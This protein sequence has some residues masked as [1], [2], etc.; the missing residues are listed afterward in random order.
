M[1]TI[2]PMTNPDQPTTKMKAFI[3]IFSA[4]DSGRTCSWMKLLAFLTILLL[5]YVEGQAQS[6]ITPVNGTQLTQGEPYYIE[7]SYSGTK[8]FP[9]IVVGQKDGE[10]VSFPIGNMDIAEDCPGNVC[11]VN[12]SPSS[13][14]TF[15]ITISGNGTP[16]VVT[17]IVVVEPC[18]NSSG[19]SVNLGSASICAGS[20]TS[21]TVNN[22]DNSYNYRLY[23][24]GSNVSGQSGGGSL[25]WTGLG[26]GSYQVKS[27]EHTHCSWKN[28]GSEKT[29]TSYNP[30]NTYNLSA[31]NTQLCSG[32]STTLTLSDSQS[33]MSYQLKDSNGNNI[34]AAKSGTGSAISWNNISAIKTY[35]VV[36]T[37]NNGVCSAVEMNNT[38]TLQRLNDGNITLSKSPGDLTHCPNSQVTLTASGG[39]NYEWWQKVG[40]EPYE[41][42]PGSGSASSI[43][44]SAGFVD[45]V[46]YQVRGTV[47]CGGSTLDVATQTVAPAQVVQQVTITGGV[48]DVCK[49]SPDTQ[50][51]A[52]YDNNETSHTWSVSPGS[53][54]TIS[55]SGLMDWDASYTGP[56]TITVR[57]NGYCGSS[58]QDSET[59]T[60]KAR[61]IRFGL[62]AGTTQLCSGEGTTITLDGSEMG[63]EY[64]LVRGTTNVGSPKS[65]TGNALNWNDRSALGAYKVVATPLDGICS[66]R[67]MD[68]TVTLERK[69][70]GNLTLSKSP[71]TFTHCPNS[72]VTLT[73]S[74]G[75]NYE[76]WQKVG[77]EPYEPVPGSGS[78]SSITVTAGFVDVVTYQVRGTVTCGGSTLDVAT[79]TVAPAQVVQQVTITGGV[80]DVCE[81]SPN[82]QFTADYDNNETS[83]TWSVNPVAAG[84]ISNSGLM[85]WDPEYDGPVTITV[86]SNGVCGSFVE[87]SET[88]TV[89]ARPIKFSLGAG[90]TQL[91]SGEGTTITLYGSELG[92][93][94]QLVR[95]TTNVGSPKSGTGN[96]L[97]WNDRSA[98]GAYKVIATPVD[99][100]CSSR[101]MDNTVTL[102][103]KDP[104]ILTLSKSPS[105][106]THCPNSQVE[107]R[108]SVGSTNHEWW[109]KIGSEPYEPVPNSA[110]AS[111]ITVTVG[112]V[113]AVTYMVKANVDC[114][115]GVKDEATTIV[116]PAQV[117]QQVTIT[118]GV[119]DVCK[120]SPDTQFTAN[121]DNNETSHTW[122]VSPVGAG[123]ISNSGLMDWD[124]DHVGPV[125]ITVRSYGVCGSV[126]EDSETMVIYAPPQAFSFS[127][128]KTALCADE[129]TTLT[130]STSESD[131]LYQLM[132]GNNAVGSAEPGSNGS[133]ITWTNI[134]ALGVYKVVATRT[135]GLCNAVEM[136]NVE[137]TRRSVGT[138]D[139]NKTP[140]TVTHCPG[141][142]VQ[143]T[144]SADG[145]S[146]WQWFQKIGNDDFQPMNGETSNVLNIASV[147]IADPVTYK[148]EANVACTNIRG[149]DTE[150]VI[151]APTLQSVEILGG[152]DEICQGTVSTN[153]TED[154]DQAATSHTW[155]LSAGGGTSPGSIDQSGTVTWNQQFTGL[156]TVRLTAYDDCGNDM[157][158]TRD[159]QVYA[160]PAVL[161]V[162]A[163]DNTLCVGETTTLTLD[164]FETEVDYKLFKNDVEQSVTP[165]VN[166]GQLIWSNIDIGTY[167]V[168]GTRSNGLCTEVEMNNPAAITRLNPGDVTIEVDA[169]P[170]SLNIP[171]EHG[172]SLNAHC[173]GDQITVRAAGGSSYSWSFTTSPLTVADEEANWIPLSQY[174]GMSS[175]D[176]TVNDDV[177]RYRVSGSETS[178]AQPRDAVAV[179]E[180][181][182]TPALDTF[183]VTGPTDRC[184]SQLSLQYGHTES[185]GATVYD[186]SVES[187]GDVVTV[188]AGLVTWPANYE[189]FTN[190][191]VTARAACATPVEA[192]LAVVSHDDVDPLPL[193]PDNNGLCPDETTRLSIASSQA[194]V[195]YQLYRVEGQTLTATG[196]EVAGDGNPID[197][198]NIG[199]GT[200]QLEATIEG[201]VCS[202]F[203]SPT[204]DI[205]PPTSITASCDVDI[206]VDGPSGGH[207]YDNDGILPLRWFG[208]ASGYDFTLD[209]HKGG[210][211]NQTIDVVNSEFE[212]DWQM[213]GLAAGNDY[214]IRISQ[215]VEGQTIEI[216]SSNFSVV[217]CQAPTVNPTGS[218]NYVRTFIPRVELQACIK[219]MTNSEVMQDIAYVDGLGRPLQQIAVQASPGSQDL[220]TPIDYDGLGRQA[221]N[222]LPYVDLTA[223]YSTGHYQ[224]TAKGSAG[225]YLAG[226]QYHFYQNATDIA[227][228]V[229]PYA[230]T[231][232]EASPLNRVAKQGSPGSV[233]QSDSN[234]L[235]TTD[236]V[237]RNSYNLNVAGDGVWEFE[238]EGGL[239][240]KHQEYA[241]G[242]LHKNET[243]D[244]NGNL[245]VTFTDMHGQTILKKVAINEIAGEWAQTYYIY[246]DL[247]NLAY[248]IQ[249]EGVKILLA[250]GNPNLLLADDNFNQKWMFSYQ[251]D[252]RNRMIAKRVPGTDWVY[253]VYDP[254]DRLVLT[255]DGNQRVK[256][257][258]SVNENIDTYEGKSYNVD[259]SA[260]LS[261]KPGFSFK[262]S[263]TKSFHASVNGGLPGNLWTFTKYDDLNRPVMTG[264]WNGGG[265]R[266][267]RQDDVDLFYDGGGD[268]YE[269]YT[270]GGPLEGY[271]NQSYPYVNTSQLLTVTYYDD[272][273]FTADPLPAGARSIVQGQVTGAKTRVLGS[274]TW[275]N[276]TTYYDHF[277]R[278]IYAKT[279]NHLGGQDIMETTYRNEVSALVASTLRTHDDGTATHTIEEDFLYD[280]RDRLLRIRQKLDGATG[281]TKI[282]EHTYNDIGE[283]IQKDL[284]NGA[285]LVDYDYNIRGW[286][287]T[288]NEGTASS[289]P[290]DKFGMS[291]SYD[292]AGQFNGN[293]GQMSWV[294]KGG[295]NTAAQTYSY[296]Y[297]QQN[298]LT[299]ATYSGSGNKSVSGLSYDHNGNILQLTRGNIDD[300]TYGY[301]GNQLRKVDDNISG[302]S[303]F[304]DGAS[305]IEEYLYDKNGNMASDLNKGI[306]LI[307]YNYLNLPEL[308]VM[309]NGTEIAYTYDAA[310]MK[311]SKAVTGG[312]STHYIG[313][314]H[315]E[316]EVG[317][318]APE[319]EFLLHAE[320]RALYDG[321]AFSY[322][323]NL[324]DHLGNVRVTVDDS[325]NAVQGDDYYPFGGTFNSSATSPENLYK[326]NGKE[327]QKETSI[328]DYGARYFDPW[329]GRWSTLDPLIEVD[330]SSS[331][332]TYVGNNPIVFNDPSGMI[333]EDFR[334]Q[335][336][337][338][339]FVDPN[340][341]VIEHRDDGDPFVYLVNNPS[342]W[343]G[344]KTGIP[345]LGF[346]DPRRTYKKGD[347]YEAYFPSIVDT[348]TENGQKEISA[349]VATAIAFG[350]TKTKYD[351]VLIPVVVGA[352][353][354]YI[355]ILK[356]PVRPPVAFPVSGTTNATD[357]GETIVILIDGRSAP[358]AAQHAYDA[359]LGGVLN[360]GTLDRPGTAARRS[361]NLRGIPTV[362]YKD[363]DEFPPAVISPDGRTS[364][365]VI[366]RA[367]NRNAGVQ[368]RTQISRFK[369]GTRVVVIPINVPINK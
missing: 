344:S 180:S 6:I 348:N 288:M 135:N 230:K 351:D 26:A 267:T 249:P 214:Q 347:K 99:G 329:L 54:G 32:T 364:V 282:A 160:P 39:S 322:Q 231:V 45:V 254:Y 127:A 277:M 10:T 304:E 205:V 227:H 357:A 118:G 299:G 38:V 338:S 365:R 126:V 321:S 43:T 125:T 2:S 146:G 130:L 100:I 155:S 343:D 181:I 241:V 363:R 247:D 202:G 269:S 284:G 4:K 314:I 308:V 85:D 261:L 11:G 35:K 40:S 258:I 341:N 67:D 117:V 64:Q 21:I 79:Q 56:V 69:D 111:S 274:T 194:G 315:Y 292:S 156:A 307:N 94:Y 279:D 145:G 204:V 352:T 22:T 8:N 163:G 82:T 58:V 74:G 154:L 290:N 46:T 14:G 186:W 306:T 159:V 23:K 172:I 59:M 262:A 184:E 179:V 151:P 280:H 158:A 276:S 123:T 337:A 114:G 17:G 335:E 132:R 122:S 275:L 281:W 340:G 75:S 361:K 148:V 42:V 257:S 246:D 216:V 332:Y 44:V 83:H 18:I 144:A 170:N 107:L 256:R 129:G 109:Q 244:E 173:L 222:Y 334:Q 243:R 77:S 356:E 1:S 326:Y 121:Y 19:E 325:G 310:G 346:E 81:N 98:L 89:Q 226:A 3:S 176:P 359:I 62:N 50:F 124:P 324:T 366:G 91:C 259:P 349:A 266:Q 78:A 201:G 187:L 330:P 71:S 252:Y 92:V 305:Q 200:Y 164:A 70:P 234:P 101:D 30:P 27:R 323:Y 333:G 12:W 61:P 49:N 268:R 225:D 57:S 345:I 219:G 228:D 25:T 368:I 142:A 220:V 96:A 36:A 190:V 68:N 88:M 350:R 15:T 110:G 339:T 60:V 229:A 358:E 293:I 264:I 34:G 48:G 140:G 128:L 248:V 245:V 294:N 318:S 369:D 312:K 76:W 331:A 119:G 102:E 210:V 233:Y 87:D 138:V 7:W 185:V 161:S 297:D 300:L 73:A 90:T 165:T 302:T 183:R 133:S 191:K 108:A 31:G 238:L 209:L 236:K 240:A 208:G 120:N 242:T 354:I 328:Y 9:W 93:E 149:E 213:P 175:I 283:L 265:T 41:P 221:T 311:L 177:I 355:A 218:Q 327:E 270:G 157:D 86:R 250:E 291:L 5:V 217:T 153:F 353:V 72:Q 134:S 28:V 171:G 289:D 193:V 263:G 115:G 207:Q 20:T 316:Q 106:F 198:L 237:V 174:S 55:N 95:G 295:A 65:G 272:Y 203:T 166:Q 37:R 29:V 285:Q 196:F 139:I 235:V 260:V 286:L 182:P 303:G 287:T 137:L 112:F 319:L 13:T 251:Y 47:T 232:F 317:E 320:G 53:A 271:T 342:S 178:C 206:T 63:V 147:A 168:T 189:N 113:D 212:Y 105:T 255:Q 309:D 80:G 301:N 104:G 298:R 143:L 360:T 24:D 141:T 152:A 66:S 273:G 278:P 116:A 162:T 362:P 199:Y 224:S 33:A 167:R 103:R 215:Q 150:T 223:T 169:D 296:S 51:T 197:W 239:P 211:F 253:M 52:N 192:V 336:I 84:T 16:I 136:G 188:D 367:D 195:I 313:G 131:I 97:N